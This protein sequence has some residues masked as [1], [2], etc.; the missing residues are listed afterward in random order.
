[1]NSCLLLSDHNSGRQMIYNFSLRQRLHLL[2]A[3]MWGNFAER[4]RHEIN[5]SKLFSLGVQICLLS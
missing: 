5:L 2:F 3:L 1:M 4:M